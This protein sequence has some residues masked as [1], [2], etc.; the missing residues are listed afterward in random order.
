MEKR[1]KKQNGAFRTNCKDCL[2]RTNLVQGLFG[3]LSLVE[4]LKDFRM[5]KDAQE[6]ENNAPF[7]SFFRNIWADNGDVISTFYAG[8]PALRSDFTRTGKITYKGMIGDGVNSVT[9]YYLNNL[10]DGDRQDAIDLFL[11]N[12]VPS[13]RNNVFFDE[14]ESYLVYFI[15]LISSM[16]FIFAPSTVR[17]RQDTIVIVISMVVFVI[18]GKVFQMRK[19]IVSKPKFRAL[20]SKQH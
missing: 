6:L 5:I 14:K 10:T 13:K 17:Y 16:F 4:Q 8:T 2:D 1:R 12:F 19:K 20:K 15:G 3:R 9:R 11:G 7:M 18:L